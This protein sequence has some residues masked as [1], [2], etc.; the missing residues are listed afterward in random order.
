MIILQS[1]SVVFSV[2]KMIDLTQSELA[3]ILLRSISWGA[4]LGVIYELIRAVK[5]LFGVEDFSGERRKKVGF[6]AFFSHALT[7]MTDIA[8]WV[9]SGCVSILLTYSCGGFFR[10]LIY[11]GLFGGFLTYY[12]TLGRLILGLNRK[13]TGKIKKAVTVVAPRILKPVKFIFGRIILLYHL[14]IGRII[15]KIIEGRKKRRS[16]SIEVDT[17]AEDAERGKEGF[18][19]VDGK[20]GYRR[21]GRVSF[22]QGSK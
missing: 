20:A 11:V 17:L 4:A 13:I 6:F 8:F 18:V 2:G 7:F 16:A 5:L 15:D 12:F 14:T 1:Q 22:G 19:Y 9:G 21:D 3:I 10:G